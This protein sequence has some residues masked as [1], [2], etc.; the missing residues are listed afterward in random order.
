[1]RVTTGDE[2]GLGTS[3]DPTLAQ[4]FATWNAAGHFVEAWDAQWRIVGNSDEVRA[5]GV[6]TVIGE[7][8]FGPANVEALRLARGGL[9]SIEEQRAMFVHVGGWLLA[10]ITGGREALRQMVHPALQDLVDELEPSDD[11]ASWYEYSTRHLGGS[12]GA[13]TAFQRVRDASGRIVGGVCVTKPAVG[14]NTIAMLVGA[15]DL[16]HFER[17][18]Q[19]ATRANGPRRSCSRISKGRPSWRSAFRRRT[20]SRWCDGSPERPT[21]AW[22]TPAASSVATPEMA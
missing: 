11:E 17:M 2:V 10:D 4:V 6:D 13:N 16:D 19:V 21:S 3:V 18:Q 14:M 20:T 9:S 8:K 1:M 5:S 15:G 22:S 12:I 7:F